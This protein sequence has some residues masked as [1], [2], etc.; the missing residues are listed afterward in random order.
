VHFTIGFAR[1]SV[2]D[3]EEDAVSAGSGTLVMI[4]SVYGILT[5]A[6]VLD[7]LSNE[8]EV[9]IV[10]YQ[11]DTPQLQRQVLQ[12][13]RADAVAI[14]GGK[15]GPSGPDLA[16]IRLPHK[17]T[18]WLRATSSFFNLAKRRDDVLAEAPPAPHHVD[19]IIGM[20]H[21]RTKELPPRRVGERR[22][23]FEAL[24][25]DGEI[26]ANRTESEY[27]L[28]DFVPTPDSDFKLPASFEG[29]SGGALWRFYFVMRGGSPSVVEKRLIGVPF[30]Q[31]RAADD[32]R[33]ITCHGP[34]G[35][36]GRLVDEVV[37]K[38][39]DASS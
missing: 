1:L 10:L 9:G 32:M 28:L 6:H 20:L 5:A 33:T 8:E 13:K 3:G 30:Y 14:R 24:F 15:F 12:I 19:A 16:L 27:D 11:L 2:Q 26:R 25:C 39:P 29:M 21:E 7:N 23:G 38:W 35:I 37:R 18:E 17:N 36:Y 34:H 22:K 4:G 31:S